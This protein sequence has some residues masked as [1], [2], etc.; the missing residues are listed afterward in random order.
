MCHM[1]T[2]ISTSARHPTNVS[3]NMILNFII[4]STIYFR[5]TLVF[6]ENMGKL[7]LAEKIQSLIHSATQEEK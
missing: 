4:Y 7:A 6:R 5:I 1:G 2:S 3:S